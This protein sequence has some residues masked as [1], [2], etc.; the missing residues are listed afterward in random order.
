VLITQTPSIHKSWHQFCRQA[1]FDRS[2]QFAG[3]L[4]P[5]S[6]L[7]VCSEVTE[8]WCEKWKA[9]YDTEIYYILHIYEC[10]LKYLLNIDWGC[11]GTGWWGGYLDREHRLRVFGNRVLRRIFGPKRDEVAGSWKNMHNE[12]LHNLYSTPSLINEQKHTL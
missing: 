2:V 1:A 3:R 4:R 12:E 10:S 5:R 7:F 11:L 6:L 9:S 8:S